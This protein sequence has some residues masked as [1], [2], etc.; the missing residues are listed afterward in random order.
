MKDLASRKRQFVKDE[1]NE[2]ALRLLAYQ[3][4]EETTID[5][6]VAAAGVSRRTFFRYFKSKEDVILDLIVSLGE[7]INAALVARP[8]GEP[9]LLAVRQS[10]ASVVR[11]YEEDPEKAARLARLVMD[12]PRVL[13]RYLER[14]TAWR[15]ELA[16]EIAR[17]MQVDPEADYQPALLAALAFAAFD[18][19]ITVWANAGG[20]VNPAELVEEMFG[21]A[22]RLLGA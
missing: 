20:T 14:Q 6:I 12:T 7:A 3:G 5:Q 19:A 13:A 4:F 22:A 2:A 17:R 1:L 9:P 15:A 10:F 11:G 21:S 8:A 18:T 16:G